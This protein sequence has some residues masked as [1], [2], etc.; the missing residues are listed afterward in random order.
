MLPL[1]WAEDLFD[2]FLFFNVS[3]GNK[4]SWPSIA[5]LLFAEFVKNMLRDTHAAWHFVDYLMDNRIDL[6]HFQVLVEDFELTVAEAEIDFFTETLSK[7]VLVWGIFCELI[8]RQ[9]GYGG[10]RV[11]VLET[12][13]LNVIPWW[14]TT[15]F[16]LVLFGLQ[17]L[18][19]WL[20]RRYLARRRKMFFDV[21]AEVAVSASE[22]KLTKVQAVLD[23]SEMFDT[24][25]GTAHK[26]FVRY[27][28]REHSVFVLCALVIGLATLFRGRA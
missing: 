6:E 17:A 14:G 5:S 9:A 13:G 19:I 24:G 2:A 15:M 12:S 22:E 7:V 21:M 28:W 4:V 18:T 10:K 11:G 23:S 20:A 16:F 1:S 8:F 25:T 3:A 26:G 27:I